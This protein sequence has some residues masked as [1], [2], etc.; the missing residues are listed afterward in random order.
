MPNNDLH[1][2]VRRFSTPVNGVDNTLH[3]YLCLPL[4]RVIIYLTGEFDLLIFEIKSTSTSDA[5]V[6]QNEGR[7]SQRRKQIAESI[8][9]DS[10][11]S[12]RDWR[13]TA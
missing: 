9:M 3:I 13:R 2:D 6:S 8:I 10:G 7:V 5:C 12:R 1:A 4:S 11:C